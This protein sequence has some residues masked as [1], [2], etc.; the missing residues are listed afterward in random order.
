[1]ISEKWP[2]TRPPKVVTVAVL[3]REPPGGAGLGLGRL[4]LGS[5]P[6]T[7]ATA[8]SMLAFGSL[9]LPFRKSNSRAIWY[10]TRLQDHCRE[11]ALIQQNK[12][13]VL[14]D[15][16]CIIPSVGVWYSLWIIMWSCGFPYQKKLVLFNSVICITTKVTIH[17]PTDALSDHNQTRRPK[18][19][20]L[21]HATSMHQ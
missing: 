6:K 7:G 2:D 14:F 18:S 12:N 1:M 16:I 11:R 4:R 8:R 17:F 3:G 10:R 5:T 19:A 20:P 13:L 15:K 21:T 9:S